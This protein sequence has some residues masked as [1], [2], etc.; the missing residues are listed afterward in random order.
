MAKDPYKLSRYK[1]L[2]DLFILFYFI[3]IKVKMKKVRNVVKEKI[4][5]NTRNLYAVAKVGTFNFLKLT[6]INHNS[7]ITA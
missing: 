7:R 2:I 5:K 3:H 4:P 1:S 6:R